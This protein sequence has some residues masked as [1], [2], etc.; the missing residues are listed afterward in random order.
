MP[1]PLMVTVDLARTRQRRRR[2]ESYVERNLLRDATFLCPSVEACMNSIKKDHV[3][4]EGTMNHLGRRFDASIDGRPLRGRRGGEES[5]WPKGPHQ[6]HLRSH[7]PLQARYEQVLNGSGLEHRYYAQD[8]YPSRNPHMRGTTSALRV[9]FGNGLGADHDG[10]F[11]DPDRGNRFHALRRLCVV[12][13]LLCS[14]SPKDD[15]RVTRRRRCSA[16][17]RPTLPR[18]W[19][20]WSRRSRCCK[21]ARSRNGP[22]TFSSPARSS[23]GPV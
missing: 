12:N 13:M 16:T 14:A 15:T 2:L 11:V 7:V 5:G 4:R 22:S 9:I 23:T 3:F 6:Q 21:V 19:L 10:E 17:A 20:S 18:P 1:S 8:G